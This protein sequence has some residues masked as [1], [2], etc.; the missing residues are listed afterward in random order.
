MQRKTPQEEALK[1]LTKKCFAW[2]KGINLITFKMLNGTYPSK[3]ALKRALFNARDFSSTDWM[4]HNMIVQGDTL[5]LIDNHDPQAK[6]FWRCN[7]KLFDAISNW[8][9][10]DKPND[11]GAMFWEIANTHRSLVLD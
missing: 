7:D 10:I 1:N 9:D 2:N 4:P 6:G 11:I 3:G 5:K 8:I